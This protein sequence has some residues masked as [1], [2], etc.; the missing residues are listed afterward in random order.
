M[1][2]RVSELY[3]RQ[4]RA[5][6]SVDGLRA[7]LRRSGSTLVAASPWLEAGKLVALEKCVKALSRELGEGAL[8]DFSH[9]VTLNHDEPAPKA[10]A[11]EAKPHG[12]PFLREASSANQ[13]GDAAGGRIVE[14][15]AAIQPGDGLSLGT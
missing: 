11:T 2:E 3:L 10:I 15:E 9:I 12:L 14:R 7:G 4:C 13:Q 1:K 6:Y 5:V 8:S